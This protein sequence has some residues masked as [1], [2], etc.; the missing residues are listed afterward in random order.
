MRVRFW[1]VRGSIPAPG[2]RTVRYGGNT[3]CV[4]MDIAGETF[5]IDA[6]TGIRELGF[7]LMRRAAG[8]PIKGRLFIGHTH[9][10]HIQG[11]PFFTP[12]F[13][14]TT[15]FSV[16]GMHGTTKPFQEVMAGQMHSTYF[17]LQLKDLG[18]KPEFH[19]MNG[20]LQAGP[21]RVTTHFLNH[22]GITVGYRFEH[23]GKVVSYISDHEPYG[24]LNPKGEFSDKEDAAVA[25]FV[26][27]SDL[28]ICEAQYTN[29]EYAVKRGWGHSTFADIL[30]LAQKAEV[31]RMAL[32]HHDPLHDD[33]KLD[34][35][36][37]E[38]LALISSRKLAIE[39][40]AAREGQVVEL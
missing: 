35:R 20:P 5:I 27:G 1:G 32:F 7:D 29:A 8:A 15:R 40:F 12:L 19:E 17:P 36:L 14:P 26:A 18:S 11:F 22:P 16:Y 3:P 13:L 25:R 21:V 9:W 10:D 24:A 4:E 34:A 2:P 31:K 6:G 33:D 39:C 37:V 38:S 28:L 23:E 30:D